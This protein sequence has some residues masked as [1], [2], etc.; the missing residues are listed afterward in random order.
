MRNI[1]CLLV[2]LLLLGCGLGRSNKVQFHILEA[3]T[4]ASGS[5]QISGPKVAVGP[6]TIPAY[7]DRPELFIQN[8]SAVKVEDFQQ[9]SEPM[10]NGISRVVCATI[11]QGLRSQQ[12]VAFPLESNLEA[13]WRLSLDINRFSGAPGGEVVLDVIYSL[14]SEHR[15]MVHFGRFVKTTTAEDSIAGLS[16]A[17]SQLLVELGQALAQIIPAS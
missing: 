12:G 16:T 4:P 15:E 6:I 9:W 10:L 2:M 11:S 17:Y 5:M 1:L 8:G 7:I 14:S 3:E 13:Q